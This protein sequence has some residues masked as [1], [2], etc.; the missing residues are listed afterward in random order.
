VAERDTTGMRT[1]QPT[2]RRLDEARR[3]GRVARS[4]DLTAAIGALGAIGVLVVAGPVLLGKLTQMLGRMLTSAGAEQSQWAGDIWQAMGGVVAT[5]GLMLAA[6]VVL[7]VGANVLQVGF[8]VSARPMRLDFGRLWSTGCLMSGRSAMRLLMTLAKIG[9]VGA[10]AYMTITA[11]V[12]N[13]IAA[14]IGPIG[15]LAGRAGQLVI[16]LGLRVGLVL[17]ALAGVDWLYQRWQHR[18]DLMMTRR[19]LE[20]ELKQTQGPGV[21]KRRQR[22][23]RG[24]PAGDAVGVGTSEGEND[25]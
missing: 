9:A 18:R 4:A 23:L 5:L 22:D 8:V 10:V 6:L 7:A 15:E 12:A 16:T 25:G 14:T 21:T 2:Q 17:L 1:E 11:E 20:D 3:D 19:E 24:R 13:V